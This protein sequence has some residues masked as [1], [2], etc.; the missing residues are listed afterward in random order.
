[1]EMMLTFLVRNVGKEAQSA[2]QA[3]QLVPD[4][5]M[6]NLIVSELRQR[7]WLPSSASTS[8][9]STLSALN[10]ALSTSSSGGHTTLTDPNTSYILDGFPR[11]AAQAS[12]LDTF[13]PVN[14]VVHLITPPST[15]LSR[16]TKR[17][18]HEPSGRVYNDDFHKP[19]VPGRDD[20]TGEPLVHRA[21]DSEETWRA[22][23]KKFQETSTPLLEH[24]EKKGCLWRVEGESSDEI[25]P[26]LFEE[27]ERRFA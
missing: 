25:S 18:V 8:S 12:S 7:G 16:I 17:W 4:T 3:G 13:V 11:T 26:K 14:L 10:A 6:V 5:T 15:L 24:Y 1:M 21:D 23:Y 2:M 9:S 22:R 27:F 19:K 20:V